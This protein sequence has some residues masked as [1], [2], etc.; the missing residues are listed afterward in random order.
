MPNPTF[1]CANVGINYVTLN[2]TD[3]EGNTATCV[4]SVTIRDVTAPAFNCPAPLHGTKLL[5]TCSERNRWYYC[6]RRLW[7]CFYLAE[8]LLPALTSAS[9]T[10]TLVI[11]VTVSV[12]DINGNVAT[13]GVPVT[14]QDITK[15]A[16]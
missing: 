1:T 6:D 15:P 4:A 11:V 13:C 5:V 8:L 14:I 7:C 16:S 9:S 3:G 10:A 12:T 2:V